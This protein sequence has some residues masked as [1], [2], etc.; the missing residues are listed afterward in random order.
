[1]DMGSPREPVGRARRVMC[2]ALLLAV[3]AGAAGAQRAGGPAARPT[4]GRGGGSDPGSVVRAAE[5][6]L[7]HD[8][9]A[10]YASRWTDAV[11]RDPADRAAALGLATIARLTFRYDDA[12]RRY[13]AL[14]APTQPADGV[15]VYARLGMAELLAR[16][17]RLP[18]ADTAFGRAAA[19]AAA[20]YDSS[21]LVEARLGMATM[22]SH[23]RSRAAGAAMLTGLQRLIPPRDSALLATFLCVRMSIDIEGLRRDPADEARRGMAIAHRA[24]SRA[25]ES[26]C[27]VRLAAELQRR[28]DMAAA[29][30]VL[31]TA[32]R[33]IVPGFDQ[34][35]L[36]VVRQY[37]AFAE[38]MLG[39]SGP[40]MTSARMAVQLGTAS[41]M[42][43]AVA[44]AKLTEAL[45]YLG[46]G[47]LHAAEEIADTAAGLFARL[48]EE[49]GR[50]NA[51]NVQAE[52]ALA[53]GDTAGARRAY[54]DALVRAQRLGAAGNAAG[55][56]EGLADVALREGRLQ[57]AENWLRATAAAIHH[58][59][60]GWEPGT[61]LA[62]GTLALR[63]GQLRVAERDVKASLRAL[64]P[65]QHGD[66][67]LTTV[68]L[69]EIHLAEGDT[70]RAEREL[71]DA[72]DAL[73][74]WRA[75]LP[76]R[77]L[78]VLAF[79]FQN[80]FGGPDPTTAL[81]IAAVAHAG[82]TAAAF[83]LAER[84]RA[85]DLTDQLERSAALRPDP[86]AAGPAGAA[87]DAGVAT[88]EEGAPGP[89][90]PH[91]RP[92]PSA[93]E[94]VQHA[95]PDDSTLFLEYVT[96][97]AGAPT[98][99][100]AIT[101]HSARAYRLPP[102]DTL[103][104]GVQRLLAL[105]LS[106]DRGQGAAEALGA[107]LLGA[108]LADAGPAVHRI[109]IVADG[110][111]LRTPFAALRVPTAGRPAGYLIERAAVTLVPSGL[112][113]A[114]IWGRGPPS[115]SAGRHPRVLAFGDPRFS[116]V[117]GA[118]GGDGALYRA[119]FDATGGLPRLPG[120]AEEA[121]LVARF[122]TNS[123][124]RLRDSASARYFKHA[125]LDSF[126][127]IHFA[128]HAI[129][130]DQALT[131]TA[132][133]L[134]PGGGES[135]FI[136]PGDLAARRLRADL[137][138]LSACRA[139]GGVIVAGEGIRGL[140]APL[141][142]AG[143]RAVV[144]SQWEIADRSTIRLMHDFYRALAE[145]HPVDDAL[146]RAELAALQRGS[147]PREWAAFALFGDPTVRIPLVVPRLDWL[148]SRVRGG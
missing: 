147:P 66:R 113:A 62:E 36:A 122:A 102:A 15:S 80:T 19:T 103:A 84:R 9:G 6:A 65:E 125:P 77:E 10:A 38:S 130:D 132:L 131:R 133:A 61:L 35:G 58:G 69:A 106:G 53:V 112:V 120:S 117:S 51:L 28:G 134:A 12:E 110:A 78:R 81:V 140:T 141:L 30:A 64:G 108:P 70:A 21:A 107:T 50:V 2:A 119:A 148:W 100:F 47:D 121:R 24:G 98:T 109:V 4:A 90:V 91:G 118:A 142:A 32:E 129:V 95:L 17:G 25:A 48:G 124:V 3:G 43:D 97:P 115:L 76:D 34:A 1:M 44:Y 93:L 39:E 114:R 40:A 116:A 37:R 29:V 68:R 88:M 87:A 75:T 92:T 5:R 126:A 42:M 99:A 79:Q 136:T 49:I 56:E 59:M 8:S 135:G 18:A 55:V 13:E 14:L 144:A 72:S 73:D 22:R 52:A 33:V 63:E 85:R 7:E 138:V 26:M 104:A 86:G 46:L 60:Q 105:M 23:T 31:D 20:A 143:A 128:T 89:A 127:V 83:D 45:V 27:A 137:V 41:H 74:R 57:V 139:G 16:Q 111:L 11:R 71:G 123:V 96:G 67:Y 145:G 54:T 101:R 94:T 146:R 82:R